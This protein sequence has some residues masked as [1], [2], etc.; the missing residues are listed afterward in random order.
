MSVPA[1][2]LRALLVRRNEL[3]R[4][5]RPGELREFGEQHGLSV[6][7]IRE[8]GGYGPD[9]QD[10]DGVGSMAELRALIERLPGD[11]LKR[12]DAVTA[13]I[14]DGAEHPAGGLDS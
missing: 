9:P 10:F 3:G 5:L 4:A 6:A 2:F 13:Q 11:A 8:L 7:Q 1:A 14:L 12:F